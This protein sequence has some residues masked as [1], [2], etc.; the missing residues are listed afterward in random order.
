MNDDAGDDATVS[1][2]P[3]AASTKSSISR[4]VA[5][6][7]SARTKDI[8]FTAGLIEAPEALA[9]WLFKE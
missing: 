5:L 4:L 3:E 6:I 9:H 7:G 8:I 2:E 1:Q